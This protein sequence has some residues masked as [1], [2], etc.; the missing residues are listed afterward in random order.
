MVVPNDVLIEA[1]MDCEVASSVFERHKHDLFIVQTQNVVVTVNI[2]LEIGDILMVESQFTAVLLINNNLLAE[3]LPNQLDNNVAEGS[4]NENSVFS[5][6]DDGGNV[7]GH[8]VSEI[9]Q[10]LESCERFN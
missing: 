7:K 3:I 10:K 2:G 4:V 8:N 9:R 1:S 6:V 5:V